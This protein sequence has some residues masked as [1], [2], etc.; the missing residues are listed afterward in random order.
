MIHQ[1]YTKYLW[2][3]IEITSKNNKIVNIHFQGKSK[4]YLIVFSKY[5]LKY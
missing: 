4:K 1:G 5:K 3:N 2:R